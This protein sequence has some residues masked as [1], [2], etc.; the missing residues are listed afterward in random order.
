MLKFNCVHILLYYLLSALITNEQ[1]KFKAGYF[2]T[3][4]NITV[5]GFIEQEF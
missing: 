3:T 2:N 5:I 1:L 4:L